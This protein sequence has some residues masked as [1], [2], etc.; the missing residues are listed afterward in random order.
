MEEQKNILDHITPK[1]PSMP[2]SEYF[3]G[4]AAHVTKE[5]QS[6]I[7]PFYKKPI[8][9][10]GSAA[11]VTIG[12]VLLTSIFSPAIDSND[13]LLALQ[14]IPTEEIMDYLQENIDDIDELEIEEAISEASL[15]VAPT[16]KNDHIEASTINVEEVT[17]DDINT[18]DILNYLNQEGIDPSELEDD[19]LF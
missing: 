2:P 11:A 7:I 15:S 6:N 18:E 19:N 17:F 3:E 12:I 10:I 13:P 4:L 9:W 1:K 14:E 16:P 5:Q 8:V